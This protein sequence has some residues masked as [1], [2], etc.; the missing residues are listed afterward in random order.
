MMERREFIRFGAA[1]AGAWAIARTTGCAPVGSSPSTETFGQGVASGLHSDSAIVLWTRVEPTVAPV[2]TV[3]WIVSTTAD[4]GAVVAS[5]SSAVV[6][7]SDHTVKVLVEGL[8]PDRSYWYRFSTPGASSPIG[9]ARTLPAPSSDPTSLRLAFASCQSFATGF[10]GAWRDVATRD[11]DAVV[12][13]GDYIYESP[14]IQLLR[15]VRSEPLGL[16]RTRRDYWAKYRHYRSDPDLRAAHAAHP[17]A[18]VWDDHELENDWDRTKL[19]TD[20]DHFR[21]SSSAWFDYQ[22]VWPIDGTRIHRSFRW[23]RL[24]ELFMLDSR[25]ARDPEAPSIFGAGLLGPEAAAPH[26]TMLGTAQR[27]WLL[28][29]LTSAHN[30]SVRWKVIGNPQPIAP[31]R[32]IDLDTPEL[33]ALDPQLVKHAGL[34]LGF[35]GWDSFPAERDIILQHLHSGGIQRTTFLSGDVHSFW[36][37][38]IRADFDDDS[39]PI[40]AHDFAG[41]AISSPP[42]GPHTGL[43]E[44]GTK[45]SPD[46]DFV[47]GRHNGF[48]L[49]TCTP[50][51][52]QVTLMG[53]DARFRRALPKPLSSFDLV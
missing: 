38:P 23:G 45:M 53:L 6:A 3:Q 29:G 7:S 46:F 52:A 34:Y 40:V 44:T 35:G 9:R 33:R 20:P 28:D 25:Q 31:L 27:A 4:L 30:D 26:R 16:A 37:G 42:G 49:F 11:L 21:A 5:G 41:G 39:S 14:S 19:I 43:V 17:W 8:D 48:G 24:A 12:F 1:G 18:I 13:L 22:P 2:A 50:D 47:D 10:Y 15:P 51:G 36:A 32:L